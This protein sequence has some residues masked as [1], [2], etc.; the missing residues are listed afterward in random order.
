MSFEVQTEGYEGPISLLLS[1]ISTQKVD[2][3]ELSIV[4]I[5]DAYLAEIDNMRQLDLEVATEF[6]VVAS[7]LLELKCRRLFPDDSNDDIEEEFAFFE[8]RDL[9]IARLLEA[10]A[11]RDASNTF[12]EL[13]DRSQLSVARIIG[14][15]EPF[16]SMVPDLLV[17]I[18][19]QK[20]AGSL[21]KFVPG[22]IDE[23]VDI[24]HLP[25]HAI[26]ISHAAR[27]IIDRLSLLGQCSF[28]E[29]ML[30]S[31]ARIEVVVGFL[32]ILELYRQSRIKLDQHSSLGE[33]QIEWV[34]GF[35]DEDEV[36]EFLSIGGFDV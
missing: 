28:S 1:L 19:L 17:N 34:T 15:D 22:E 20:L 31:R 16:S 8:E 24:S 35:L 9:L 3:W 32:A 13:F 29:L 10:K 5:V 30:H 7:T 6:L 21:A 4:D 33:I 25:P 14:L 23:K 27:Q 11:Y 36:E 18:T 26:S 12:T 2:L